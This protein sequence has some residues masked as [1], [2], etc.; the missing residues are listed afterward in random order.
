[1]MKYIIQIMEDQKCD[2]YLLPMRKGDDRNRR[3]KINLSIDNKN[4]GE[5]YVIINNL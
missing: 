5:C 1:M 2:S 3:V 4:D